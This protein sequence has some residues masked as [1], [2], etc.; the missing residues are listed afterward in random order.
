MC[1][2]VSR[3]ERKKLNKLLLYG[4]NPNYKDYDGRTPLHIAAA[5][6][7]VEMAAL[8][9]KYQN[10]INAVD[11]FGNTATAGTLL[12]KVINV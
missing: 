12:R 4:A 3:D 7:R 8:L 9:L 1:S 2:Y 5:E 6:N 11:N 10:D